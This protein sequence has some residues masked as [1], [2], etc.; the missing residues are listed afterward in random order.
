MGGAFMNRKGAE[1]A[2]IMLFIVAVAFCIVI[3]SAFVFVRGSFEN[4][5]LTITKI[6]SEVEFAQQYAIAESAFLGSESIVESKTSK[7]ALKEI[8]AAKAFKVRA[9]LTSMYLYPGNFLINLAEGKF[10]FYES[11]GE[12]ILDI[13]NLFIKVSAGENIIERKYSIAMRF[14]SSGNLIDE[15]IYF[16]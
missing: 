4:N 10:D 12:Y 7:V 16:K 11:N 13:P 15:D 2:I 6:A 14:D 5:S 8:M 1:V 3:L 9:E